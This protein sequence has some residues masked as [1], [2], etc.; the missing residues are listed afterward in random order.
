MLVNLTPDMAIV[1]SSKD[2]CASN[3]FNYTPQ[4]ELLVEDGIYICNFGFNFSANEFLEFKDSNGQIP[5]EQEYNLFAPLYEK[6]Q[7][8]VA[9]NVEQIKNYFK[10]EIEDLNRKF[11]IYTTPVAQEKENKGRGGGW[12]WE[13][14]GE[15]I[16]NLNPQCE[17]LD[18]EEFGEDFVGFVIVFHIIEVFN[19]Q[20]QK[21]ERPSLA[22][23]T[24]PRNDVSFSSITI[25][26]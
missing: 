8:G 25:P 15:Y 13:K 20:V 3:G 21:I 1:N 22:S 17:Y 11:F 24:L 14:W 4:H 10:E 19:G 12:R 18:D 9:D 16:G 6:S 5:Y 23:I 7:Y 2:F 26:E